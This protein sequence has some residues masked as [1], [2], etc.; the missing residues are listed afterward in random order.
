MTITYLC[1][2]GSTGHVIVVMFVFCVSRIRTLVKGEE[3]WRD[4]TELWKLK[5]SLPVCTGVCFFPYS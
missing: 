2:P 5:I 3:S 1:L 4:L